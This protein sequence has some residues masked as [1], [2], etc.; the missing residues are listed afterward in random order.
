MRTMAYYLP[1]ISGK[2][3]SVADSDFNLFN[4]FDKYM[5]P[6]IN[7]AY[8]LEQYKRFN[9]FSRIMLLV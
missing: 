6:F 9:I 2:R 1:S 5:I 7:T 4:E 3:R 8:S